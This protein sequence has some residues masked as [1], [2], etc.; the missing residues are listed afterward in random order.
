MI[1]IL[2]LQA[3]TRQRFAAPTVDPAGRMVRPA[4]TIDTIYMS[5]QEAPA[6]AR[7]YLPSGYTI[8][9]S[10]E[11]IGRYEL[12]AGEDGGTYADR[13]VFNGDTYE[14]IKSGRLPPFLVEGEHWECYAVRLQGIQAQP[15]TPPLLRVSFAGVYAGLTGPLT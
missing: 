10:I 11:L 14:I 6:Q 8:A 1:P 4:P 7:S 9:D 2:A 13:V 12:L 5:V 3:V 15:G